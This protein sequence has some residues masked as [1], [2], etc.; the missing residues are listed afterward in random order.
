MSEPRKPIFA[1]CH[2]CGERW[3][4]CITPIAITEFVSAAQQPRCANCG[5]RDKIFL[6]PTD[7]PEKVTEPR[8]GK[9]PV[10]KAAA[11]V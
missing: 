6:C 4:L 7:G 8:N 1:E 10:E 11:N 5:E 9:P 2:V 3:K